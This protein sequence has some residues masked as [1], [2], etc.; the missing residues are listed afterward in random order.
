MLDNPLFTFGQ[1]FF[2]C[3]YA[4]DG[5]ELQD[6]EYSRTL[7][8]S[9]STHI[10]NND[11]ENIRSIFCNQGDTNLL[12]T[13]I[14]NSSVCPVRTAIELGHTE[15]F[16]ALIERLPLAY[17]CAKEPCTEKTFLMLIVEHGQGKMTSGL[18]SKL[19]TKFIWQNMEEGRHRHNPE[20]LTQEYRYHFDHVLNAQ[21]INGDT[22]LML[23]T[24]HNR[25]ECVRAL[26]CFCANVFI[27]NNNGQTVHHLAAELPQNSL[28]A[29]MISDHYTHQLSRI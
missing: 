20:I 15:A 9:L 29:T 23:A 2:P 5:T 13:A 27:T 3:F 14:E 17:L 19:F 22:A 25:I 21:D 8:R 7:M 12:I 10:Q 24:Q 6:A 1:Y 16:N 4:E 11:G 18:L 28:L 26:I